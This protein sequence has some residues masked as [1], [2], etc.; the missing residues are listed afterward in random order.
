MWLVRTQR[1]LSR[2]LAY[3]ELVSKSLLDFL[4]ELTKDTTGLLRLN[5][6]LASAP[7]GESVVFCLFAGGESAGEDEPETDGFWG[8]VLRE[9]ALGF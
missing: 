7:P 5:G 4:P 3:D 1:Q 9:K 6:E 8:V 2:S